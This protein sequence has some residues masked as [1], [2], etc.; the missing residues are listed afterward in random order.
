[1]KKI[2]S[3]NV[4]SHKLALKAAEAT[5]AKGSELGCSIVVAIVGP[6]GEL[7]AFLRANGAPLPSAK[8]AQ[9]KAYSAASF[10][11]PTPQ[12]YEMVSGN[13]ALRDGIMSQPGIA[14]FG[15][16]LPIEIDGEFVGAI[17]V[18]GSTEEQDIECATA[19]LASIGAK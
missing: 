17:G 4:I 12:L 10:R 9:D 14:L 6:G 7:I 19:G 16:G 1:M 2:V 3:V 13:P 8:I 11:I 15:G 5:V 18:S